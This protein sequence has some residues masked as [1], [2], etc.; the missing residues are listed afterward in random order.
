MQR[1]PIFQQVLQR[2]K[3]PRK[4]LQPRK[5]LLIGDHGISIEEFL[6]TP[7]SYWFE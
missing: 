4:F 2:V 5:T 1:R 6:E 3:E 7:P